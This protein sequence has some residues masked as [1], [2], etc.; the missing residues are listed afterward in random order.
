MADYESESNLPKS[1]YGLREY[2]FEIGPM[3]DTSEAVAIVGIEYSSVSW[4]EKFYRKEDVDAL[5]EAKE[6]ELQ[7]AQDLWSK[8]VANVYTRLRIA[9]R[10]LYKALA[11]W[12]MSQVMVTDISEYGEPRMWKNVKDRCIKQMLE[13]SDIK[14]G[15]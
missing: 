8:R 4:D 13:W 2:S 6:A 11:N 1:K 14:Q 5:L 15:E 12:A 9:K 3:D 10:T 7:K